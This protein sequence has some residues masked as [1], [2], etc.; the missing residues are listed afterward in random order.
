MLELLRPWISVWCYLAH[1]NFP[2]RMIL[3]FRT[4]FKTKCR[5]CTLKGM[6]RLLEMSSLIPIQ[7]SHISHRSFI[8]RVQVEYPLERF[9]C[10]I[11]SYSKI[12][13]LFCMKEQCKNATYPKTSTF[14]KHNHFWFYE[15]ISIVLV[16]HDWHCSTIDE[17]QVVTKVTF[18]Q[19]NSSLTTSE[20]RVCFDT[21][22]A[23]RYW[24]YGF[25]K[26]KNSTTAWQKGQPTLEPECSTDF[27]ISTKF[28]L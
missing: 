15:H 26:C 5:F 13:Q 12:S 23:C 25:S 3:V 14:P 10:C 16:E 27:I 7:P 11:I 9:S 1:M 24:L 20:T 6:L 28:D 22:N 2:Q 19:D 21:D 8:G 4:T 18:T 17:V